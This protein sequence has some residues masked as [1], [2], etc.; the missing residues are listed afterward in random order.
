MASLI[1]VFIPLSTKEIYI[2]RLYMLTSLLLS[3]YSLVLGGS[4]TQSLFS[5]PIVEPFIVGVSGFAFMGAVIGELLNIP[6]TAISIIFS[7]FSMLILSSIIKILR[8]GVYEAIIAGVVMN[9]FSIGTTSILLS[10]LEPYKLYGINLMFSSF[11]KFKSILEITVYSLIIVIVSII[12]Y[13]F[14]YDFDS[15][16][17]GDFFARS[18]GVDVNKTL[19]LGIIIVSILTTISVLLTGIIGFIGIVVPHI[20]RRLF[21]V[22]NK[23][24]IFSGILG[25]IVLVLSHF[26]IK[27]TPYEIP[28]AA[29]LFMFGIPAFIYIVRGRYS[30]L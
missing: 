6:V 11:V 26:L 19:T 3:G 25:A 17:F 27:I 7:L 9:L 8:L 14:S 15:I 22:S 20:G 28:I 23:N 16:S 1:Y 2:L 24:S 12:S 21:G 13:R 30:G 10:I 29:V 4:I 5:N 18:L